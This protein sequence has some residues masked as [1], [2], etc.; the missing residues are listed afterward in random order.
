MAKQV[1]DEVS[2]SA[3]NQRRG[4]D[5]VVRELEQIGRVTQ[6][7][8]AGAEE[9]ASASEQLSAQAQSMSAISVN[10]RRMVDRSD[11]AISVRGRRS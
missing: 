1:I 7:S 10:L 8:A 3:D 9:Q 4:L 2:A 11:A 6:H 5:E